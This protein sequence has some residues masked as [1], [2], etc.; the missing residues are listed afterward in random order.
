MNLNINTN[1]L[2]CYSSLFKVGSA[3]FPFKTPSSVECPLTTITCVV[4]EF[5]KDIFPQVLDR[6]KK[7]ISFCDPN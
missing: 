4:I 1:A 3:T 7:T 5:L 2:T 6:I